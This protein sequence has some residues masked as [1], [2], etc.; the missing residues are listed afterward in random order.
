[1]FFSIANFSGVSALLVAHS[2]FG[3]PGRAVALAEVAAFHG[4]VVEVVP[5]AGELGVVLLQD[6]HELD[7]SGLEVVPVFAVG[8]GSSDGG[9]GQLLELHAG[10]AVLGADLLFDLAAGALKTMAADLLP[11]SVGDVFS[12][13]GR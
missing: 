12:G 8:A 5:Q 9:I 13:S 11:L 2:P 6:G 4:H 1:M 3:E 10:G 7:A